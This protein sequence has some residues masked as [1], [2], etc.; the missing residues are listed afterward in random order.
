M[1]ILLYFTTLTCVSAITKVT[2]TKFPLLA[3]SK[4]S[5]VLG[6]DKLTRRHV[7]ALMINK[8]SQIHHLHNN[9]LSPLLIPHCANSWPNSLN[10]CLPAATS[11]PRLCSLSFPLHRNRLPLTPNFLADS[12]AVT[13]P[14]YHLESSPSKS[15]EKTP[16][17]TTD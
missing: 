5:V 3:A 10:C 16:V 12:V 1:T 13:T 17:G 14:L 4:Q 7:Q 11:C 2:S 6:S 8:L 15:L 9:F